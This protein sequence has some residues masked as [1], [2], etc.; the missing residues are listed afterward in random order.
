MPTTFCSKNSGREAKLYH[1]SGT[2]ASPT[3]VEIKEARDLS[4]NM[5]A[6][7]FEV[8]D[9]NTKFKMYGHGQIDVEI[10]GKMTYRTNNANCETIRGLFL[11][12]CGA[13]FALM[14]NRIDGTNGPAEGIRGGF[15][16]FTNS[17]EFPLADGATVDISLK[18]C[19]FENG[20]NVFV[21]LAWYDVAGV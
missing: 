8:S 12:G 15:Q 21:E 1:N 18:P 6:D 3:W 11:T 7:N 10:S 13:E 19:Y 20:S 2:V 9:R 17:M 4:L 16:V 5:T 14:S